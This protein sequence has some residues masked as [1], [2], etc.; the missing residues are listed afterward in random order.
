MNATPDL[1]A[2]EVLRTKVGV[3]THLAPRTSLDVESE[4]SALAAAA[5]EC[6]QQ[7]DIHLVID[8]GY[9]QV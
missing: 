3:M 8:L 2:T 1:V 9:V 7:G 5:G 4:I 6:L